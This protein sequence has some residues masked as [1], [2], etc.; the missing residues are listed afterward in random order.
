M[1]RSRRPIVNGASA[2]RKN[3]RRFLGVFL[4]ACLWGPRGTTTAGRRELHEESCLRVLHSSRLCRQT[5]WNQSAQTIPDEQE[6]V[7][8]LRLFVGC[9]SLTMAIGGVCSRAPVPF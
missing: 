6:G 3:R 8:M 5:V 1:L 7:F 4:A 9:L 2:A